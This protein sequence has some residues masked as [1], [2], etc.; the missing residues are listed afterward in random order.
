VNRLI[1]LGCLMVVASAAFGQL[2]GGHGHVTVRPVKGWNP[3]MI[4]AVL[5]SSTP[6]QIPMWPYT[7]TAAADRGGG[8][9]SGLFV[10]RSPLNRAK[11]TTVITTQII[12]LVI[13]ITDGSGSIV[14]DPTI[15]DTCV[16]GSPTDAS[17]ITGSPIFTNNNY[18]MNGVNVTAGVPR[19]YIDAFVRANWWTYVQ[20]TNYHLV[21]NQTVLPSAPLS[22][23]S[24]AGQNYDI[25][26]LGGCG[27]VGVVDIDAFDT[28]IQALLHT[29][30]ATSPGTFPILLTHNVV[31][32]IPGH[33]LFNNCCALGYHSGYMVGPN[34]QIYSPFSLDTSGWFGGDVETLSHEMSEAIMDPTGN[35]PTPAWGNIGQVQGGCQNNLEVGDPLSAAPTN[36]FTIVGGNG[37]TYHMQ[38]E[39]FSSWFYGGVSV[40]AGG[41][42]SNNGTFHGDAIN[43]PPGGTN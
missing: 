21:L 3:S 28:A 9:F 36:P 17:I 10:G 19:Q 14:Y 37:I 26:A 33:D 20:G 25:G 43:C 6:T 24:T 35:N 41:L 16:S 34:L 18:T 32:G 38:E 23:G 12:P 40:G 22:F 7:V 5:A 39:A 30:A 11:S 4:P 1:S 29:L 8:T 15:P 31:N 13:T 42:F 27:F 2:P